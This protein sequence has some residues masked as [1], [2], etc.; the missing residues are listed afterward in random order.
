MSRVRGTVVLRERPDDCT[1]QE[2]A[3]AVAQIAEAELTSWSL[4]DRLPSKLDVATED[5]LSA[6]L[7]DNPQGCVMIV[8]MEDY[9]DELGSEEL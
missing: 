9:N 7:R 4:S 3:L 6:T 2:V 1:A 5:Q 8:W